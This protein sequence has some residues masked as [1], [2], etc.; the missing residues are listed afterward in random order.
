MATKEADK[1]RAKARNYAYLLLRN[2]PRSEAE[3]RERLKLKGYGQDTVEIVISDLLKAGH[4]DDAKF[5]KFLIDSRM[6]MNP[7]GDVLL[8]HQLKAK[9]VSD[10]VI[11]TAIVEKGRAYDEYALA[12]AM[13]AERFERLKR[14][15]RR[16]ATKRLYDFLLRRGFKYETVRQVLEEIIK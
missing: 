8:K 2:R 13:A 12:L 9:G 1:N 7:V 16:K 15:D 6:H 10:A 5:A 4:I 3:L 11:D 14:L